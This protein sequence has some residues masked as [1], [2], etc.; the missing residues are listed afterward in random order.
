[1]TGN[2]TAIDLNARVGQ[3]IYGVNGALQVTGA[4]GGALTSSLV[5]TATT[6]GIPSKNHTIGAAT[7]NAK[8]IKAGVGQIEAF[9]GW[10]T[11]AAY[12]KFYDK[13]TAPTVGTDIPVLTMLLPANQPVSVSMAGIGLQMNNG[14]AMAITLNPADTDATA[15]AAAG[16]CG[17]D[18]FYA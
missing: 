10:A 17:V 16:T 13:A 9:T 6:G 2:V 1:M 8:V 11:T 7:T 18:V 15:L 4:A 12:L 14:I 5:G 3:P